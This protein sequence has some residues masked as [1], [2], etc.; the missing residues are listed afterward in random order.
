MV[1]A[2][3]PQAFIHRDGLYKFIEWSRQENVTNWDTQLS[4]SIPAPHVASTSQSCLYR[5]HSR[6]MEGVVMT[7]PE[8]PK[9]DR[10]RDMCEACG[11]DKAWYPK[12][13]ENGVW[14]QCACPELHAPQQTCGLCAS[15]VWTLG[16]DCVN[17]NIEVCNNCSETRLISTG[18]HGTAVCAE[19][20]AAF[21]A[22]VVTN[23]V[24]GTDRLA[25]SFQPDR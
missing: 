12:Q 21:E 4:Q 20:F 9:S 16:D 8:R 5:I 14:V 17:C 3:G 13:K 24:Y 18:F 25:T 6:V 23:R 11:Y 7:T 1:A 22:T 10:V 15:R 19:C 2:Q